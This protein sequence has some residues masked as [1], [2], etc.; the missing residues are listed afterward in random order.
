[1]SDPVKLMTP[2]EARALL[3]RARV[4]QIHE[5]SGG[6][7]G[8]PRIH[9]ALRDAGVCVSITSVET[10]MRA[11]N[12]SGSHKRKRESTPIDYP[13]NLLL[14]PDDNGII[15]RCFDVSKLTG[16]Y[17]IDRVWTSDMTQVMT[18]DGW[19]YLAA[20]LDLH[21]RR[22]I[23]WAMS[24]T[25]NTRLTL[26]ALSMAMSTR[27][28]ERGLIVHSDRGVQYSA[29]EYRST[30]ARHGA[31]QSMS[32]T[33]SCLDNAPMESSFKTVKAE[34]KLTGLSRADTRAELE[35]Y[36]RFYNV[37]RKHSALGNVSPIQFEQ[38]RR[39][40]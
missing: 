30:L 9:D 31:R 19:L 32:R 15:R 4:V 40:P 25:P 17:G 7:Y 12:I 36:I 24:E 14:H 21:S 1:M 26:A 33:A 18:L 29:D 23:G 2:V 22:M 34:T 10:A 39:K 38:A 8:S 11:A 20:V 28:P 13:P 27:Q 37:T 35:R 16:R 5:A 3:L 6:T